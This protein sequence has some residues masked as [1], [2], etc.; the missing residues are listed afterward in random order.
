MKL[1][2]MLYLLDSDGRITTKKLGQSMRMS[3][4]NASYQKKNLE[5][6]G[7]IEGYHAVVD[8]ARF[9]YI[10]IMGIYDMIRYSSDTKDRLLLAMK[11]NPYIVRIEEAERG[12]DFILEYCVPNLSFFNK[13][14]MD[15][16]HNN[17]ELRVSRIYSMIVKH[18]Y[19]KKYMTNDPDYSEVIVS[20]DRNVYKLNPRQLAVLNMLHSDGRM[21][22]V[23]IANKISRDPKTVVLLKKHLEFR[24]LILKYSAK[25]NNK[26][27]G[28]SRSLLFIRTA[29]EEQDEMEY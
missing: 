15:F 16:L 19:N 9:G 4:Q 6:K 24:K 21:R 13:L 17:P 22:L 11:K 7:V 12:A 29:H 20:G 18:L 3:Q 5:K 10:N 8:P 27:A 2:E 14:H 1:S 28:I 25:F 26:K 23:D